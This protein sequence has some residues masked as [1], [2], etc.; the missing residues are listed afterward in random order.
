MQSADESS[1]NESGTAQDSIRTD[2]E[3]DEHA[4]PLHQL[5]TLLSFAVDGSE[6]VYLSPDHSHDEGSSSDVE[7]SDSTEAYLCSLFDQHERN[8]TTTADASQS[9]T[10]IGDT[11]VERE[12]FDRD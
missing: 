10:R 5:D 12:L 11:I 9:T 4:K 3:L 1:I 6:P 7:W 2:D 8:Q